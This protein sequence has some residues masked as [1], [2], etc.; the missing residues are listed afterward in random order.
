LE[1]NTYKDFHSYEYQDMLHALCLGIKIREEKEE[2][3]KRKEQDLSSESSDEDVN[4]NS[5]GL[6][7][8]ELMEKVI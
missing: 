7:P 4:K 2:T 8:D 3:I 5:D 1:L 6:S